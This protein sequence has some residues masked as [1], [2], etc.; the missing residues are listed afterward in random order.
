MYDCRHKES[1]KAVSIPVCIYMH[2]SGHDDEW[3]GVTTAVPQSLRCKASV[4]S[5]LKRSVYL[6]IILS[7]H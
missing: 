3:G 5:E 7:T 1:F 6:V 4:E 2:M